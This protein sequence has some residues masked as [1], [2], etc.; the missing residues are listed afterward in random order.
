M[1]IDEQLVLFGGII[2]SSSVGSRN[3]QR[4]AK[5][6]NIHQLHGLIQK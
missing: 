3:P 6:L 5:D 1:Q 2:V 4:V